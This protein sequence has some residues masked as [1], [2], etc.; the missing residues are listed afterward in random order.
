ML[1]VRKKNVRLRPPDNS[2]YVRCGVSGGRD[3]DILPL[4][5]MVE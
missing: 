3:A 5:G 1:C 2:V 4:A